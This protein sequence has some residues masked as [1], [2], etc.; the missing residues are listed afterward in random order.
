MARLNTVKSFRGTSKTEDGNLTCQSCREK[1]KPGD[2]YRWWANR[3]PGQRGSF[4]NI[5]CMKSECTPSQADMT[6]GRAG[7]LMRI[8]EDGGS[9][10]WDASHEDL[11][12][13]AEQLA[14]QVRE[15][16]SELEESAD[17][18]ES[19]FGHETQQSEELRER[20]EAIEGY[21]DELEQVDIDEWSDDDWK[22]DN[23][24]E[25]YEGDEDSQ[26]EDLTQARESHLEEQRQKVQDAL[27]AVE[28][29]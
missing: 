12:G 4:R 15:L 8:Q 27:D 23:P 25:D 2:G 14:E 21:A 22:E 20:A 9:Q 29:Y 10:I 6:P 18:I 1:I 3:L 19:G 11:Q 26:I 28:L 7:Q 13:I 24:L 17:N 16:A 5:R